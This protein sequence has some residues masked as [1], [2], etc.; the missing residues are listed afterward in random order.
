MSAT[1]IAE[2]YQVAVVMRLRKIAHF[3]CNNERFKACVFRQ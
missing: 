3:I 1:R 2:G